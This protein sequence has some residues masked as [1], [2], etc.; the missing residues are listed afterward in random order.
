ML[1]SLERSSA[2]SSSIGMKMGREQARLVSLCSAT[3]KP[4]VSASDA[5][6]LG[7]MMLVKRYSSSR[8]R[9]TQ[10][11]VLSDLKFSIITYI[12]LGF[13][14]PSTTA[15]VD[16]SHRGV[17]CRTSEELVF[18]RTTYC[19]TK[20]LYW[21]LYTRPARDQLWRANHPACRHQVPSQRLRGYW[22]SENAW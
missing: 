8:C 12:F 15:L 13:I 22:I 1:W 16:H 11:L 4:C 10:L 2:R 7:R 21:R 18:S 9:Q 6:K 5:R 19:L 3:V 14:V 17:A 20:R